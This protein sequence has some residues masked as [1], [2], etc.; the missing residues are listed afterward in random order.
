MC[1]RKLIVVRTQAFPAKSVENL[2]K[3]SGLGYPDHHAC[4]EVSTSRRNTT[5]ESVQILGEA[6]GA[7]PG[8][9]RSVPGLGLVSR[10]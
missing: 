1:R 2:D 8:C 6:F 7:H 10:R 4:Q 3:P 5:I 9:R